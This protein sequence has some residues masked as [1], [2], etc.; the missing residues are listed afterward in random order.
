[1]FIYWKL[2]DL[3]TL[4]IVHI[5]ALVLDWQLDSKLKCHSKSDTGEWKFFMTCN[6]F[7]VLWCDLLHHYMITLTTSQHNYITTY[8]LWMCNSELYVRSQFSMTRFDISAGRAKTGS[9][10]SDPLRYFRKRTSCCTFWFS[11]HLSTTN[12][13]DSVCPWNIVILRY[14]FD[15]WPWPLTS[16]GNVTMKNQCWTHL[17]SSCEIWWFSL[18]NV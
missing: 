7:W 14:V 10:S 9:R 12:I 17:G 18:K 4:L 15:L 3:F 16:T 5:H 8:L 2:T 6:M 1:M 11:S 13:K